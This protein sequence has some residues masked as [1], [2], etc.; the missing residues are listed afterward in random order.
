M[1]GST[2]WRRES[3][4]CGRLE[5]S[6]W[7][8][9]VRGR[10]AG[11][12]LAVV[13]GQHGMEP[14]GP[15]VLRLFLDGLDARRLRGTL[16]VI[17]LANAEALRCGF[18]CEVPEGRLARAQRLGMKFGACPFRLNR[19]RCGRNLNR[20]WPGRRNGSIFERLVAVMWERVVSTADYV[21]DFHCWQD[22]APPG[23]LV[24]DRAGLAFGRAFRVPFLHEY[25]IETDPPGILTVAAT[26]AGITA[27]TVELTPQNRIVSEDAATAR[28]G[29]ENALRVLGM[30]PGRP[31]PPPEQYLF[32][33]RNGDVSHIRP[34]WDAVV[35]PACAAGTWKRKGAV[36]GTAVR[37]DRPER[38]SLLRAPF[39][40][41]LGNTG[42]RAV[43]RAG[44]S[45]FIFHRVRRLKD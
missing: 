45:A 12:T 10:R 5:R 8:C 11:P 2:R 19:N 44:E 16:R 20:L 13:A 26:R 21:V 4:A 17:P 32:R 42:A 28:A 29:L 7:W 24:Y 6:F 39:S 35:V 3:V 40:G 43:V 18:E 23:V 25:D 36:L 34:P 9:E 37:L 33:Y 15:G 30:L 38:T 1:K 14:T 27:C 31:Q 22:W 41:V